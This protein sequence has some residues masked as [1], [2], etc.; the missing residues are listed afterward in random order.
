MFDEEDSRTVQVG[1]LWI[2]QARYKIEVSRVP[3]GSWVLIEG[4]DDAITKTAT[5][6]DMAN[7]GGYGNDGGGKRMTPSIQI[8]VKHSNFGCYP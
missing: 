2:F 4:V 8:V 6:T 7:A 5:I 1:R 3:A